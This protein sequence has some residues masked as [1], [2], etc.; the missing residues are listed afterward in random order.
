MFF[1]TG[2][3]MSTRAYSQKRITFTLENVSLEFALSFIEGLGNCDITR[4]LNVTSFHGISVKVVN[5]TVEEALDKCLRGLPF[6]YT[7]TEES[8][9]KYFVLHRYPAPELKGKI[10]WKENEELGILSIRVMNTS[11]GTTT[12]RNG[13]FIL[14]NLSDTA[15][16]VISGIN[17]EPRSIRPEGRYAINVQV[18]KKTVN[19]YPYIVWPTYHDGYCNVRGEVAPPGAWYQVKEATLNRQSSIDPLA[20]LNGQASGVLT[21]GGANNS[22]HL[23]IRGVST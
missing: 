21:G 5:V 6:T 20:P 22:L 2:C 14:P 3:L 8:G 11:I 18:V 4:N 19:L 10:S 9:I 15:I 7:V 13:N 12:D 23:S 16:L 17:I 1:L